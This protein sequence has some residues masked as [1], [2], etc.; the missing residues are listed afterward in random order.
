[1]PG[2]TTDV[3]RAG[4]Y[5]PAVFRWLVAL[6]A[7]VAFLGAGPSS[8]A[9]QQ[10]DSSTKFA[11]RVLEPFVIDSDGELQG[12]SV[13]LARSIGLLADLE[14]DFVVVDTVGEQL[15]AVERGDADAAIGAIS[16]TADR[17]QRV[18]FSLPMFESG[19]SIAV[20]TDG[21]RPS[22]RSIMGQVFQPFLA[23]LLAAMVV[24]TVVVGGVVWLLE[25][26]RNPDFETS[27]WRGAFHGVWWASVTLFTVGYGDAVP[28]RATSRL[29]SMFWMLCGVLLVATLTAEVTAELTVERFE[30]D[31]QSVSDLYGRDVVTIGGTTSDDF[32]REAGI[33]AD[34]VTDPEAAMRLLEAGDA[35]AFVYDTAIVQYL[36]GQG[37]SAQLAGPVLQ[38]E[39]YGIVLPEASPILEDIDRALLE[40]KQNGTYDRLVSAYFD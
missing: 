31:I 23:V 8:T 29:I 2:A 28:R 11:V 14:I 18:D 7:T 25:R 27:G 5:R 15:E 39:S 17:E 26:H 1:M 22:L 21:Q 20:P 34:S 16:I 4:W 10:T 40:L 9:A 6:V 33:V 30:S 37:Y 3:R 38:P 12:F 24:G 19:I 13:D 35:D 36:I 32:L